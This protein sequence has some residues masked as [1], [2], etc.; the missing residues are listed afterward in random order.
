VPGGSREASSR[1]G[2]ESAQNQAQDMAVHQ[3]HLAAMAAGLA[4]NLG[5]PRAAGDMAEPDG[6]FFL[7]DA[8]TDAVSAWQLIP[9]QGCPTCHSA[10]NS[11]EAARKR[12]EGLRNLA[13][14]LLTT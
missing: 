6:R 11:A 5:R 14:E 3:P 13:T 10:R 7:I 1:G 4:L 8:T 2:D 12:N 9:V